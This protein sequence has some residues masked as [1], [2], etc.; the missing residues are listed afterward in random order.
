VPEHRPRAARTHLPL[1]IGSEGKGVVGPPRQQLRVDWGPT[2]S[3]ETPLRLA[4]GTKASTTTATTAHATMTIED[5]GDATT[6]TTTVT[7]TA[8]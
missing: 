6:A 4:D 5:T 1:N 3:R 2:A 8:R 7:A